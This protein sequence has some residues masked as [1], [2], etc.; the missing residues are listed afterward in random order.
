MLGGG[1]GVVLPPNEFDKLGCASSIDASII[2]F[3]LRKF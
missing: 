2:A 3:G 1:T